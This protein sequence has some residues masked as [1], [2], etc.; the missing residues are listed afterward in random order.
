MIVERRGL[1][2]SSDVT[3]ARHGRAVSIFTVVVVVVSLQRLGEVWQAG[4]FFIVSRNSHDMARR[5]RLHC[6]MWQAAV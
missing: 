2:P 6:A 5:R 4:E 1:V 3:M